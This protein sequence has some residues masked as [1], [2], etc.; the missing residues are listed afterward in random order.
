M[1]QR[2]VFSSSALALAAAMLVACGGGGG[3]YGS[4][5][6]P[7]SPAGPGTQSTQSVG[8]TFAGT[9]T[10]A[11]ARG[12][13]DLT[14]T[15]VTVSVNGVLVGSGVLDNK[16]HVKIT[17]TAPI[18]AGSTITIVAGHVTATATLAMGA[19]STAV[20]ITVKPDGTITVTSAGDHDGSGVVNANDPDEASEDEDDHGNPTS[21]NANGNVLPANAPF[22]LVSACGTLTL[23]PT[24]SAVA[25]IKFEE[26]GSDGESDDAGR[27]RFEGAFTAA[28]H[29]PI[30]AGAAR[31]HIEIFDAQHKRLIEV[32]APVSAFT[33]GTSTS[34]GACPSPT[35]TPSSAPS[36]TPTPEPS[37]SPHPS[38]SPSASPSAS[39]HG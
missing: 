6:V 13:R 8:V 35:V 1:I 17:F 4:S 12:T 38:P 7:G 26:K 3:G 33:S 31:L 16:G 25:S 23:T 10:L 11:A 27:V 2:R 30:V 32:K 9:T 21:V 34:A 18:A 14:S 19:S 36:A 22:T 29:F 5:P 37:G 39:P 28:L 15:P 20:L 24:S